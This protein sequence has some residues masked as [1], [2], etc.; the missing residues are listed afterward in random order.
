[1]IPVVLMGVLH[2][3]IALGRYFGI[4]INVPNVD[5][6]TWFMFFSS[7]LAGAMTLGGVILTLKHE[8]KVN[9]YQISI[10]SIN[11][12]KERLIHAICELDVHCLSSIYNHF[13]ELEITNTGYRGIDIAEIQ[14]RI[15]EKQRIL[16]QQTIILTASTEIYT[17]I[18]LQCS[19]CKTPCGLSKV[20]EQFQEI[21]NRVANDIYNTLGFLSIYVK[22]K[23]LNVLRDARIL[24]YQTENEQCV[25]R[26]EPLLHSEQKIEMEKSL[27]K[28]ISRDMEQIQNSSNRI[29]AYTQKEIPQL[30]NLTREYY[31]IKIRNAE[32]R[33]FSEKTR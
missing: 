17:N 30:I 14:R 21:Y 8:R 28:D 26:N 32:R 5:A 31:A 15:S 1:M 6:S 33:C 25:A 2:I 9:Q 4:N 18:S 13:L 20:H 10:A 7:Y 22:Q 23:E 27:K 3:G 19:G 11:Q 29:V 16:T 24:R 12:E